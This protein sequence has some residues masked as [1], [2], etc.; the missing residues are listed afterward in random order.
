MLLIL[1]KLKQSYFRNAEFRKYLLYAFGEMA[2]VI[3]GILIALQIDNW[4]ANKLEQEALKGYLNTI[5]SNIGS[6][7]ASI[8]EL[9]SERLRAYEL[10]VVRRSRQGHCRCSSKSC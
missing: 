1:R 5:S 3:I 7:L 8:D 2:L 9:R 4:N 10:S 6:D